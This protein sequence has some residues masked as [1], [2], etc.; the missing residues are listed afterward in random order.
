MMPAEKA[1]GNIRIIGSDIGEAT[2]GIILV[3]LHHQ[4]TITE[5]I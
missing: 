5:K 2:A 4:F 3:K 1:A